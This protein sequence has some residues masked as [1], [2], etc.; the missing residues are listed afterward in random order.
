[1]KLLI[2]VVALIGAAAIAAPAAAITS[3]GEYDGDRHP[4]VA[5]LIAD[6]RADGQYN[7]LCTGTLVDANTVVSASHCT[8]F[9]EALDWDVEMFVTFDPDLNDGYDRIPAS[10]VTNPDYVDGRN[11]SPGD[12]A[13]VELDGPAPEGTKPARLPGPQQL[14]EMREDGEL[15]KKT[16]FTAVGYGGKEAQNGPGG[17]QH[18]HDLRRNLAYS[19]FRSLEPAWLNLSQNQSQDDGGTCYGDSGGPNFLGGPDADTYPGLLVA[20]TIT[21]DTPCKNSNKALR[22]DTK[23]SREFLRDYVDVPD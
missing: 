1:M 7:Q 20:I 2:T 10:W 14:R 15:T 23:A 4:N 22:L 11:D 12:L 3:N 21:G 9:L 18:P 13:V 16:R 19:S 6:F 17:H 8:A 5:A